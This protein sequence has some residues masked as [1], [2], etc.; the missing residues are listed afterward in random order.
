MDKGYA[1]Y[2]DQFANRDGVT[3]IDSAISLIRV[4]KC[5]DGVISSVFTSTALI[6]SLYEKP[7]VSYNPTLLLDKDDAAVQKLELLSGKDQLECVKIPELELSYKTK[8]IKFKFYGR[9]KKKVR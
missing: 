7:S 4:I 5:I 1:K 3:E 6:G 2:S 8:M 9:R